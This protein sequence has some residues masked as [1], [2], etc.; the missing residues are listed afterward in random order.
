MSLRELPLSQRPRGVGIS[1]LDGKTLVTASRK[2]NAL[3]QLVN[4]LCH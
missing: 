2:I 1:R 4:Y 3:N